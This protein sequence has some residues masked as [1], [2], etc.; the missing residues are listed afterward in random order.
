MHIFDRFGT[1]LSTVGTKRLK[2][3]SY[4]FYKR[5]LSMNIRKKHI[6]IPDKIDIISLR[7]K[8]P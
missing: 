8:M 5:L 3:D 7:L 4:G 1:A 2:I 6:L